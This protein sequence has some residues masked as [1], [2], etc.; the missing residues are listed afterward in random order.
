MEFE[1]LHNPLTGL[2]MILFSTAQCVKS[3]MTK[4]MRYVPAQ[5]CPLV[6][7]LLVI[8]VAFRF[9]HLIVALSRVRV[10]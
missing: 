3:L 1:T 6:P 4:W 7:S 2:E 9:N 8:E 5:C 10:E